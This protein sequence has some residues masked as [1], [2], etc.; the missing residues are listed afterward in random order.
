MNL[1][2]HN[3]RLWKSQQ[4]RFY[5]YPFYVSCQ[6]DVFPKIR[7]LELSD[8]DSDYIFLM[9]GKAVVPRQPW[10]RRL[11]LY[12]EHST[13]RG[14]GWNFQRLKSLREKGSVVFIPL[15][16]NL[17]KRSQSPQSVEDCRKASRCCMESYS[18]KRY[19]KERNRYQRYQCL[20][21][22]CFL[23]WRNT[24]WTHRRL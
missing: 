23:L 5:R 9:T 13:T 16:N 24:M 21:N 18:P 6:V 4:W 20:M 14:R 19:R 7:F 11:P 10:P 17:S 8:T 22:T 12:R 2:H 1:N 15:G 3:R